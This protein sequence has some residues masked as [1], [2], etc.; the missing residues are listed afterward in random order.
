MNISFK[1]ISDSGE[2][3]GF[4]TD[5]EKDEDGL[6]FSSDSLPRQEFACLLIIPFVMLAVACI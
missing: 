3:D 6:D 4:S 1:S 2:I 5:E